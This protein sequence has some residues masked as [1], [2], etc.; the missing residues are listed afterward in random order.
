M[1]GAGVKGEEILTQGT[2]ADRGA[3]AEPGRPGLIR[4]DANLSERFRRCLD[5]GVSLVALTAT[6]PV[7][8]LIALIIR[9]DFPGP[10]L[11]RQTRMTRDRRNNTLSV[12]VEGPDRR[13]VYYAGRPF[14][15]FKFRTMYVD[16][17]E[18]FPELYAYQYSEEEIKTIKFKVP[19]DPRVTR[20]GRRLRK[21]SLD[22]LPNFW[23]VLTGDTTLCG[24]RP[25]IPEMSPYYTPEQLR[26][27]R[28]TAGLTGPAQVG[29]AATH[30][31]GNCRYGFGVREDPVFRGDIM[32]LWQTVV[33]VI[34]R[35]GAE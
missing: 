35:R 17:R 18:R 15:F 26:K 28:V 25:E 29:G 33:A 4:V 5:I 20:A 8:L 2:A 19:N 16:A 30:L 6:L 12:T 34:T 3:G 22:E 24:P 23:N 11:F 10:A 32:I 1:D 21:T 9:L 27:F 14:T 7:M 31:P 13:K